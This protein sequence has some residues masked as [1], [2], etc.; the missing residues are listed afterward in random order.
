MT[1]DTN[2]QKTR[3]QNW[4]EDLRDTIVTAFEALE[5]RQTA[6]P[7]ESLPAGRFERTVTKRASDDG[8]DAGG[9]IVSVMRNV[10]RHGHWDDMHRKGREPVP[11]LT[12]IPVLSLP[13]LDRINAPAQLPARF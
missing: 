10:T 5:D 6:G 13:R 3:A 1:V 12:I 11:C 4:F 2:A 7:A 9:G 8:A